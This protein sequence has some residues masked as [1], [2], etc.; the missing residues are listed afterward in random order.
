[1]EDEPNQPSLNVSSTLPACVPQITTLASER[2][3]RCIHPT[4]SNQHSVNVSSTLPAC[5]LQIPTSPPKEEL[6]VS[7]PQSPINVSS[8]LPAC[9]LQITTSPPKD[10]LSVSI[11][12]NPSTRLPSLFQREA[13]FYTYYVEDQPSL[14]VSYR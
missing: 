5:V 7:I 6:S 9:V 3:P 11:P 12:Q 4:K 8:T 14:N 2:R 13:V 10:E 1:M